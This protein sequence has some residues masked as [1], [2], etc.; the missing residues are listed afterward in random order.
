MWTILVHLVHTVPNWSTCGPILVHIELI[1]ISKIIIS[2]ICREGCSVPNNWLSSKNVNDCDTT[3][4]WCHTV[5]VWK[6]GVMHVFIRV[7][8]KKWHHTLWCHILYFQKVWCHHIT[9]IDSLVF[10]ESHWNVPQFVAHV[11]HSSECGTKCGTKCG[12]FSRTYGLESR[13]FL[14]PR[15]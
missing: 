13:S 6:C 11:A 14:G 7:F 2:T 15:T 4:L 9:V 8:V 3:L 12:T 10:F 1:W 5:Y